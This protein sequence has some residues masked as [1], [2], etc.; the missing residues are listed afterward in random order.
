MK[1]GKGA[2]T[3]VALISLMTALTVVSSWVSIPFGVVPVT[4]QT[5]VVYVSSALLGTKKATVSVLLYLLLGCV[6]LPVFSGFRGGFGVLFGATGGY[7]AGFVL[8]ALI[9]GV[10]I[11]RYGRKL[12]VMV[13]AFLTGTAMCYLAGTLWYVFVYLDG[14][15]MEGVLV[16][17]VFPFIIPD[18]LKMT[19]AAFVSEAVGKRGMK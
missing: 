15:G 17:C 16:T 10:I 7:V 8:I 13:I 4:L 1:Q 18:I 14:K 2:A 19:A 5:F 12:H 6:G 9:S 11:N 3:D